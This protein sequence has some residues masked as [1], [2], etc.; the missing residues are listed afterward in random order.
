MTRYWRPPKANA[1]ESSSSNP[2]APRSTA[3]KPPPGI[4]TQPSDRHRPRRGSNLRPVFS[5]G[6]VVPLRQRP[7]RL[8][9]VGIRRNAPSQSR[10]HPVAQI[11]SVDGNRWRAPPPRRI[12]A[13][14]VRCCCDSLTLPG[15]AP[16]PGRISGPAERSE[17][18][19]SLPEV[20]LLGG[21]PPAGGPGK[22]A[23]QRQGM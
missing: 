11:L 7:G 22:E 5:G 21:D 16:T 3:R 18:S 13:S 4:K 17:I 19:A 15:L 8:R 23:A 10:P 14:L 1:A 6:A 9:Q 2:P 20:L 12:W